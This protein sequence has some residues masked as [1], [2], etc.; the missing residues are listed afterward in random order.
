MA[1][2]L[3]L[4]SSLLKF[5]NFSSA[6]AKHE[7]NVSFSIG[8]TAS[9]ELNCNLLL[10]VILEARKEK[11]RRPIYFKYTCRVEGGLFHF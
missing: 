6:T 7:T 10:D 11:T 1:F 9:S 5:L 4:P 8:H 3:L 2:S